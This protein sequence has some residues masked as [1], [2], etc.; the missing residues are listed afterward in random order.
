MTRDEAKSGVE[1]CSQHRWKAT[2][3]VRDIVYAM[4]SCMWDYVAKF[5]IEGKTV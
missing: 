5:Y 2:E 3:D 4:L 1:S